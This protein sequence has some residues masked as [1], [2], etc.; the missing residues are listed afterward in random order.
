MISN[1]RRF[2]RI[3]QR[4]GFDSDAQRYLWRYVWGGSWQTRFEVLDDARIETRGW[5][6]R[7]NV[8]ARVQQDAFAQRCIGAAHN[9][10]MCIRK[11]LTRRTIPR[12]F[13]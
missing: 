7:G 10:P 8:E 2:R 3:E 1:N 6:N 4:V 5:F 12:S 13:Y 11:G 9:K